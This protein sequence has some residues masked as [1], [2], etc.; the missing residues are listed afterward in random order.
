MQAVEAIHEIS[1]LPQLPDLAHLALKLPLPPCTL[2][3]QSRTL[4][5]ALPTCSPPI[6]TVTVGRLGCEGGASQCDEFL[7]HHGLLYLGHK[8]C[9][10]PL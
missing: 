2:R 5:L 4:P 10:D 1:D 7:Q 6:Y 8:A 3:P 9:N